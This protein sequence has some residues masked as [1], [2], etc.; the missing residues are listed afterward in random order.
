MNDK[1]PMSWDD[2]CY[3]DA[4]A[5]FQSQFPLCFTYDDVS[6]GTRYSEILPK[7]A[8]LELN[9]ADRLKLQLPIISSDMDTVTEA[10]MAIAM[11]LEGGM[12]IIHSNMTLERQVEE[13]VLVK[14]YF[15]RLNA[16][17]KDRFAQ[18]SK[19]DKGRLVCGVSLALKRKADASLDKTAILDQAAALQDAGADCIGIST[20]HGHSLGVGQALKT[21]RET[22]PSL[23]LLAGN[24]TSQAGVDYLIECGANTIKV[25]Q[26]PGSICTTRIVAGVGTPQLT[27]LYLARKALKGRP[28]TL[29]ADGGI[30]KS[31]DMV[32]ALTLAD[33]VM[34]GSLFAGC[35]EA[36]GATLEINGKLYKEY[37]G[38]GSYKS[39]AQGSA[40]RYGHQGLEQA[41]SVHL[42][43][44]TAEGVEALK[45]Y[46]GPLRDVLAKL[47]GGIQA[48]MGYIGAKDL[49]SLRQKARYVRVSPAGQREA[50]I[51]DVF[52]P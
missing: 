43:K 17:D 3:L 50:G 41:S 26:G 48:G 14:S 49:T 1:S 4:D 24:V 40:S 19:D 36:P 10:P 51:H 42:Q 9:L 15:E 29:L 52:I 27:A 35:E 8:S 5:F 2:A 39:M 33:G 20:A 34:C 30:N 21:L 12:G 32:K 46:C 18:A 23:L 47:A 37:R 45:P 38:M 13:V 44:R 28:V 6:L 25:G 11:A 22:F 7:E 31:G 16:A